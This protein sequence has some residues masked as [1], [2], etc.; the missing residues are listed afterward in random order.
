MAAKKVSDT[1]TVTPDGRT[2]VD[3]TKLFAK[4]HIRA[5][6][7]EMGAKTI[8]VPPRRR[9]QESPTHHSATD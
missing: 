3:I 4:E 5:M 1:I 2:I 7:R 6:I 9:L 8:I